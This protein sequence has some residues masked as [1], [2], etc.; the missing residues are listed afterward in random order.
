MLS[1]RATGQGS[2]MMASAGAGHGHVALEAKPGA[3]PGVPR[4]PGPAALGS[5]HRVP[6]LAPLAWPPAPLG[7]PTAAIVCPGLWH[8]MATYSRKL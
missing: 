1:C 6:G 2:T 8:G 5:L 7:S 3:R 4:V